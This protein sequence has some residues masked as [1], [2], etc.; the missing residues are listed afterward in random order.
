[1]CQQKCVG[2]SFEVTGNKWILLK[3]MHLL[4]WRLPTFFFS[5]SQSLSRLEVK[6]DWSDWFIILPLFFMLYLFLLRSHGTDSVR[7]ILKFTS[8]VRYF[9]RGN[10]FLAHNGK[11]SKRTF[12]IHLAVDSLK[13]LFRL[14]LFEHV[15]IVAGQNHFLHKTTFMESSVRIW[16]STL[17]KCWNKLFF[18]SWVNVE[19]N[20]LS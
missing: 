13:T 18:L 9:L 16:N 8:C 19:I 14:I 4:I 3:R 12:S 1:M 11:T 15:Q 6:I 5:E 20:S 2:D 7:L 17:V 10:T